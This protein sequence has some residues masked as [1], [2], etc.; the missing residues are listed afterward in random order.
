[1]SG[2]N[3]KAQLGVFVALALAIGGAFYYFWE[4][5]QQ[6]ELAVRQ[7]E[8]DTIDGRVQK[9]RATARELDQ[10]RRQAAEKKAQLDALRPR[11]PDAKDAADLLRRV[12][13]LALESNLR[14]TAFRPQGTTTKELHVEWPIELELEGTYHNLGLFL[15]KVSKV[16]RIINVSGLALEAKQRPEPNASIDI[17]CTATTFVLLET[18]AAPPPAKKGAAKA[19]A[20]TE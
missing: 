11:L 7:R 10:F 3:W 19:P 8:F 15:D 5:P 18:P 4:M 2:L 20:K 13:T 17:T 12:N 16:P 1:L 14:V 9:A 6:A